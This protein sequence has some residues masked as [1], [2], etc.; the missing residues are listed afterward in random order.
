MEKY[1]SATLTSLVDNC[2]FEP[3]VVF[4]IQEKST[5]VDATTNTKETK[6]NINPMTHRADRVSPD[7]H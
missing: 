2:P 5:I 3:I 6:E 7:S 1:S 4:T